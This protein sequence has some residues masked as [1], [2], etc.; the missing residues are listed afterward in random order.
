[1]MMTHGVSYYLFMG[2][3]RVAPVPIGDN[4]FI[5]YG[6]VII[7]GVTTENGAVIGARSVVTKDVPEN[8]IVAGIPAKIIRYRQQ[9]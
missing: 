5:G 8:A 7:P 4:C 6:I 9:E 3:Y 2:D 1:M